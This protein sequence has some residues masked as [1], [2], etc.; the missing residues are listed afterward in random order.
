MPWVSLACGKLKDLLDLS[1]NVSLFQ[2]GETRPTCNEEACPSSLQ[3]QL[4]E[5]P[6]SPPLINPF[7][8]SLNS[9]Y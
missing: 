7:A 5:F 8:Q 4:H 2:R 9:N 6:D 1:L 3:S